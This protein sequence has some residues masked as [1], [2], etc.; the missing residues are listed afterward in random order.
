M[1]YEADNLMNEEFIETTYLYCYKRLNNPA[2]AEDLAQ[3]ILLEA[4]KTLRSGRAETELRSF[5]AWYWK[6]AHNK[7]CIFLKKRNNQAVSLDIYGGSILSEDKSPD[8]AA[9]SKEEI[10]ELNYAISRLSKI[11][12]EVI[13]LF[14][15]KEKKVEDIAKQLD[16]PAGT[17]KR[18]LFD[19]KQNIK[20]GVEKMNNTVGKSSYAPAQL[21]MW[22]S[23]QIPTY[24]GNIS[25]IMTKQIFVVCREKGMT[26]QE[27]ADEIGVAPLYFEEKLNYL[28]EN[29]FLKET[30]KGKYITDFVILPAQVYADF[31]YE[32]SGVYENVGEEVHNAVMSVKDSILHLDF[33]GRDFAYNYLM[34]I[35]YVYAS[36][37][38][39]DI[40][41]IQYNEKWKDKVPENN[42]KDY[43]ITGRVMIPDENIEYKK[44]G[45]GLVEWS[46]LHQQFI[47]P[48][49]QHINYANLFQAAPFGDRDKIV[50]DANINVIMKIYD[51]P[52]AKLTRTEEEQAAALI[53]KGLI[54][55]KDGKL[56]LDMPVMTYECREMI[57][58]VLEKTVE[59]LAK[60]YVDKLSELG[61]KYFRLYIRDDLSEEYVHWIMGDVFYPLYYVFYYGMYGAKTLAIPEDYEKSAA[62]LCLYVRK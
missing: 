31:Y 46:N 16:I 26:V 23:Y 30:S 33:Y 56:Y 44:S 41:C 2:D 61:E 10:S 55:K 5:Y 14:Y 60:K 7:Y 42:G 51:D 54:S 6:M 22:G 15:L 57:E 36:Q 1:I 8:E 17:V 28:L 52:S 11:Q 48:N 13:V 37:K 9:I 4:L 24:W 29:K 49:Y 40:M 18:R 21:N 58:A 53:G 43:R 32:K 20:K 25:D 34:W 38:L 59:N 50:T 47:T 12:R 27:I 3:E 39:S 19:A 45:V 62:G 35:L